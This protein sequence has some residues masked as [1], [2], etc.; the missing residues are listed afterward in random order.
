V[1]TGKPY[2]YGKHYLPHDAKAK[3]LA[4]Q[5]KSIIEQLAEYL[6]INNLAIVPD[7]SVQDGIQAVRKMLPNTW[8]DWSDCA[9]ASRRCANISA[10]TTRTR[11][12]F[13]RRRGMIG[14]RTR[15]TR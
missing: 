10:S 12:H 2:R 4:A 3:T 11:K 9:R 5:G 13:G 1:V 14:A 8:F 7:L 6:G 15:P